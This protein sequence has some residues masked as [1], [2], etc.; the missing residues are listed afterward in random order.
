MLF[1]LV[2]T[3]FVPFLFSIYRNRKFCGS[4]I[5]YHILTEKGWNRDFLDVGKEGQRSSANGALCSSS[6]SSIDRM[7]S[8]LHF[9]ARITTGVTIGQGVAAFT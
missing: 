8:K 9:L 1:S 5:F 7:S 2:Q 6:G 3:F 4:L